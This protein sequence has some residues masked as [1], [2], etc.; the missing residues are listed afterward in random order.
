M[1][2]LD[3]TITK[4]NITVDNERLY[5]SDINKIINN[6]EGE[7]YIRNKK[8]Y[9]YKSD[10]GLIPVHI[11][12]EDD[13][14][15]PTVQYTDGYYDIDTNKIRSFEGHHT[16]PLGWT[17]CDVTQFLQD[18]PCTTITHFPME[19]I[20]KKSLTKEFKG[21]LINRKGTYVYKDK[22]NYYYIVDRCDFNN[23]EYKAFNGNEKAVYVEYGFN[24]WDKHIKWFSC[25]E[26]FEDLWHRKYEILLPSQKSSFAYYKIRKTGYNIIH[27]DE[28]KLYL[29]LPYFNIHMYDG[30][31]EKDNHRI[32]LLS[33]HLLAIMNKDYRYLSADG[34]FS[35][36]AN[37]F[38]KIVEK[39]YNVENQKVGD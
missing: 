30:E 38:Y 5:L 35:S 18:C 32:Y 15:F 21:K 8:H 36:N 34:D 33:E 24:D 6:S 26:E 7:V 29:R 3:T 37:F 11:L 20:S 19:F 28:R 9:L 27:P 25:I 4:D 14:L 23:K 2:L 12:Q 10:K 16:L 17:V 22:Y 39:I 31:T 13:F 1:S